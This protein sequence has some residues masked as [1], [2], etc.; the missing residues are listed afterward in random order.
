MHAA[1]L[2]ALCLAVSLAVSP[3]GLR[4]LGN[5][6]GSQGS[7]FP[8]VLLFAALVH[9]STT[10]SYRRLMDQF[11]GSGFETPG[12]RAAIGN[13]PVMILSL[14]SR[15]AF[16]I[17]AGTGLL[18]T[19][20]FTFNEVFVY[21]F[22]NFGFAFLLLG[23]LLAANLIGRG[24][25][26][27]IQITCTGAAVAGL[28]ALSGVGLA[29]LSR[30]PEATQ[31]F[32]T[33]LDSRA[34]FAGLLLLVGF[35]LSGVVAPGGRAQSWRQARVMGAGI[36]LAALVLGVWGMAAVGHTAPDKLAVSTIPYMLTA[37]HIMG[38]NGRLLI[39]V[40][41]IAGVCGAVN[42]L[43]YAVS[44]MIAGMADQGMLPRCLGRGKPRAPVAVCLLAGAIAL[45]LAAGMAGHPELNA[46]TRAGLLFWLLNYAAVHLAAFK[47]QPRAAHR[48]GRLSEAGDALARGFG[49]IALLTGVVVLLGTDPDSTLL[50]KFMLIVVTVTG[51][52][53]LLWICFQRNDR[54]PA[55][56]TGRDLSGVQGGGQ[57]PR[58]P[59]DNP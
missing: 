15:V 22:P 28:L 38:Q 2:T 35:D 37:R 34:V 39:G 23:V 7:A 29:G 59:V 31:P 41:V 32:A 44:H 54:R 36:I 20:G 58:S 17:C 11:S 21:W 48:S 57:P 55:G 53:G 30:V 26:Q 50:A 33:A 3:D 27:R 10:L 42:A 43:L 1:S 49:L 6:A 18:A 4:M 40:V 8:M 9:L 46:Y 13:L 51:I 56:E 25:P 47:T 12:L 19:A 45:M 52:F 24:M 5:L 14:G 16:T